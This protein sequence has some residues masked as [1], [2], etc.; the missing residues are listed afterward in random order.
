MRS[1]WGD[2]G[3]E[4]RNAFIEGVSLNRIRAMAKWLKEDGCEIAEETWEEVAPF[5]PVYWTEV[6]RGFRFSYRSRWHNRPSY[7]P[8]DLASVSHREQLGDLG[9]WYTSLIRSA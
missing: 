3:D 1:V 7:R 2:P 4:H 8:D 5:R 6:A 9:R